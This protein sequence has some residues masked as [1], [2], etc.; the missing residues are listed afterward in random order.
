M[1]RVVHPCSAITVALVC[2]ALPPRGALAQAADATVPQ[3]ETS[4]ASNAASAARR[5]ARALTDSAEGDYR[6][7]RFEA[8][9]VGYQRAYALVPAPQLLFNIGQCQ[10]KLGR[11]KRAKTFFEAYLRAWPEAPQRPMVEQLIAEVDAQLREREAI[12]ARRAASRATTTTRVAIAPKPAE[13]DSEGPLLV[14]RWWFWTGV[15]VA[16]AGGVVATLLLTPQLEDEA[17]ETTLG[18]V[19]WR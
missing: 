9:A 2:L 12:S 6:G 15:G 4:P 10:R 5:E 16:V 19:R 14:E 17:P 1:R 8:A 11:P 13:D 18:T 3:A 7:G